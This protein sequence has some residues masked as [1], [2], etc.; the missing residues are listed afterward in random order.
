MPRFRFTCEGTAPLLMHNARLADPLDPMTKQIRE[1]S[2]KRSKTDDD[3]EELAHLEWLGGLYFLPD[4][5][6]FIP[7]ANVQKCL[8]EGARFTKAGKKVERGVFIETAAVPVQYDGPRDLETLYADKRFVFR[9]S[10]KVT[11]SRVM[12]TRPRFPHWALAAVGMFDS[13][14]IDLADLAVAARSAGL[15]IGLGDYRPQFGRFTGTVKA[16]Q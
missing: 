13:N 3:H 12:R 8:V 2:S 4:V 14:V 6:P 9:A 10:V 16:D 7:A 11:T 15:M 5:G 1:V